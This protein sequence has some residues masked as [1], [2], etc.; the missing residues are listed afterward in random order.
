MNRITVTD[1]RKTFQL[2]PGQTVSIDGRLS[3]RVTVLNG[4]DLTIR[5]GEFI[6]LVG[7]SGS[8]KSVLLDIIG[9]LT[10][11]S[12]G[13]VSIDGGSSSRTQRPAMSFSNTRCFPGVRHSPI[14]SMHSRSTVF[15]SAS[16]R[17]RHDTSFPCSGFPASRTDF[18]TSFPAACSSAS[19]LQE[20]WRPIQKCC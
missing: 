17:R 14:S 3:D 6:T 19:Q 10:E 15:P 1:V 7:P 8:G 18:P 2:K 5:K 11:A 13:V 12:D 4:I 9:G 20:R 16:E